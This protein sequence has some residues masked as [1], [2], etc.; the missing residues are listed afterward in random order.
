MRDRQLS[1]KARTLRYACAIVVSLAIA[2]VCGCGGGDRPPLGTV[3]GK[4]T[5]D[6]KPLPRASVGFT[7]KGGGHESTGL[8]DDAGD[9]ELKYIRDVKGAKVGAHTV[10]VS[11]VHDR[12]GTT[13]TVPPRYNVKSTLQADVAA[14]DNVLNFD[15]TTN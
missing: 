2:G 7:P 3:H 6:G 9:Y 12:A 14:G 13:E 15:L 5:L 1:R 4:I 11:T 8:T 10:S